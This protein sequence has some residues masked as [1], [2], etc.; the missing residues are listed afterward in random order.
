MQMA[1]VE[2]GMKYQNDVGRK[3]CLGEKQKQAED[4]VGL[5]LGQ[6][7][8]MVVSSR[9]RGEGGSTK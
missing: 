1:L 7:W 8:P 5:E 2:D 9:N 3:N 4:A 6:L